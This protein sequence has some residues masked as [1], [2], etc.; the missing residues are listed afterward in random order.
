MN[1]Q[2]HKKRKPAQHFHVSVVTSVQRVTGQVVRS[3]LAA[4]EKFPS[5][6][7][8]LVHGAAIMSEE[9]G[10]AVKA[11]L[12]YTYGRGFLTHYRLEL[13]HTAAMCVR[14]LLDLEGKP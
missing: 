11:A 2:R 5:W 6:P 3:V 4:E 8:D 9:A 13:L 14:A 1:P 12:D 10:E 7:D